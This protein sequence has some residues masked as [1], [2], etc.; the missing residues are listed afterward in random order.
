M[1]KALRF[2]P[3]SDESS[4]QRTRPAQEG[5][6]VPQVED[7][8][9]VA[10]R[11]LR[12]KSVR[13]GRTRVGKGVFARKRYL[14]STVIGEIQGDVIEDP[15]YGSRYCMDIGGGCV[16]EPHAPFRYV[17]HSCEP[18][19]E[20]DFFDLTP[21][22]ESQTHRHVYLLALR[23]IKPGEEL[24][25]DYNWSADTAIPCRCEAS[26]CRGW[27]VTPDQLGTVTARHAGLG[28]SEP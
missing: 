19:C 3:D 11:A 5:K 17:N 15:D 25:I 14:A 28:T 7:D 2:R 1:S 6:C 8:R 27:I 12:D 10:V 18:N 21:S 22:G 26:T 24:T 4:A 20:F 13:V 16:L 9:Q 23:E